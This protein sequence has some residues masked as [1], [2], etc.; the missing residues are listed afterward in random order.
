MVSS[1]NDKGVSQFSPSEMM[2]Q[3]E[4]YAFSKSQKK[5]STVIGLAIMAGIFIGLAFVFYITVTTGNTATGWG[6][7]RFAGGL[8]F[9][10][11]LIL[12]VI[13]GGELFTSSVLSAIAVANKQITLL[14]MGAIWLKVYFGNFIGAMLLLALVFSAAMYQNDAG[15]WGLNALNIA[16]HK[17]H[18]QPLEAFALGVLCNLL[19]C[20]AIWLTFCSDNML[21]KA[22]MVILPVAMFVSSGFEHSVANMFMV[23]LGIAIKNFAPVTF[24]AD[25]AVDPQQFA[26]LTISNFIIANLIPVTL[27]NIFGGAVM[28]GL[29]YWT[30]F[31]RPQ[32]KTV[33]TVTNN[34]ASLFPFTPLSS[35]DYITMDANKYVHQIMNTECYTLSPETP[36]SVALDN[37]MNRNLTGAIVVNKNQQV[38]GFFSEH[39]VL[40]ELW[41]EDYLPES[42]RTVA[43]LMRPDVMSISPQHTLLQLAEFYAIDKEKLYPVSDMGFATSLTSLSVTDRARS[44]KIHK[45]YTLPV[46]DNNKLVGIIT[47][48]HVVKNLRAI[49]T[50]KTEVTTPEITAAIA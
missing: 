31:S 1:I 5:T 43:S 21:T 8:A 16:Q 41:C 47:R 11:G 17:L 9:S 13:T 42:D 24:W 6:I 38:L 3:A 29:A 44:M 27:G 46:I 12:V 39:D 14:Q 18:H 28:V 45:P 30:I 40:V 49:Y 10:M 37:L 26:D 15:V 36:V 2:Q 4:K 25:I 20:L 7:S 32:L 19:V 35:K 34:F 48:E 50:T 23:P 33:Q 22:M